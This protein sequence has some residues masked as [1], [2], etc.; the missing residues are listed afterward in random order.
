M[1]PRLFDTCNAADSFCRL[2]IG[3]GIFAAFVVFWLA[4]MFLVAAMSGWRTLAEKYGLPE[5][6]QM[7]EGTTIKWRSAALWGRFPT[8]YKSCLNFTATPTGLGIAPVAIF[9]TGHQPLFIPWADITMEEKKILFSQRLK[10][11]IE[12]TPYSFSVWGDKNVNFMH[13]G[14][15]SA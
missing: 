14:K 8:N 11:K 12:G 6:E 13:A 10:L 1:I 5:G 15:V 7:P 4:I 2:D 9:S 3:L